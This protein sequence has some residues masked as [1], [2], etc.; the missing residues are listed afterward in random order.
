[1]EAQ[2]PFGYYLNIVAQAAVVLTAAFTAVLL[3]TQINN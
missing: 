2:Q 3:I 1:M